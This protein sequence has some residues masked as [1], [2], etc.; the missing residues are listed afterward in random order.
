MFET[1]ISLCRN[2]VSMS[3]NGGGGAGGGAAG[4]SGALGRV[5]SKIIM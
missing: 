5:R 3:N 2:N 4:Q 1:L